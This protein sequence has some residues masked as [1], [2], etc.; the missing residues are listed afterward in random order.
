MDPV[1]PLRRASVDS[2]LAIGLYD[3]VSGKHFLTEGLS[4][5]IS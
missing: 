1:A 5:I 3:P 4:G 2:D